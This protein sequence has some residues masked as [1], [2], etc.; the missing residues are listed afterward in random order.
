[1]EDQLP[2]QP[3]PEPC[4]D[5]THFRRHLIEVAEWVMSLGYPTDPHAT[6]RVETP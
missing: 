1:M 4:P 6:A 5:P 2:E 3:C